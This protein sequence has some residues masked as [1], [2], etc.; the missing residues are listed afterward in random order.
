MPRRCGIIYNYVHGRGH[1]PVTIQ[2]VI[3][4]GFFLFLGQILLKIHGMNKMKK[5]RKI[6]FEKHHCQKLKSRSWPGSW[7]KSGSWNWSSTFSCGW[8]SF[9]WN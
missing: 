3:Q 6:H 9:C 7:F 5:Y 8:P 1:C 2:H 4:V